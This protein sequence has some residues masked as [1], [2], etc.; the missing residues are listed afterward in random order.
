MRVFR[1][2]WTEIRATWRLLGEFG[3]AGILLRVVVV[4][5]CLLWTW[6]LV[7]LVKRITTGAF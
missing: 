2:I 4:G 6:H 7:A 1:R 3:R 5:F